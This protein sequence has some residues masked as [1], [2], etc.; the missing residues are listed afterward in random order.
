[1]SR[2]Q[3]CVRNRHFKIFTFCQL[4]PI[5]KP[6]FE[7]ATKTATFLMKCYVYKKGRQKGLFLQNSRRL[8]DQSIWSPWLKQIF[9]LLKKSTV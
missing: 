8:F 7:I 6:Y 1:M 3:W 2:I 5:F 4:K 9:E